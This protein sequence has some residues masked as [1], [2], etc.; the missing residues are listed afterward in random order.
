M[1]VGYLTTKLPHIAMLVK[2]NAVVPT[3]TALIC[4]VSGIAVCV[5]TPDQADR[6][7][8]IEA[9]QVGLS[10][11]FKLADEQICWLSATTV[12]RQLHTCHLALCILYQACEH[13]S[14]LLFEQYELKIDRTITLVDCSTISNNDNR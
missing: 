10:G 12:L 2:E 7:H 13:D 11:I 9:A 14:E 5:S 3:A 4:V 8:L 1:P 6:I